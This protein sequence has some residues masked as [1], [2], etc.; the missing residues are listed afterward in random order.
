MGGTPRTNSVHVRKRRS[1][2]LASRPCVVQCRCGAY[3]C[4]D[5]AR[6][7]GTVLV[8]NKQMDER[9]RHG[10]LRAYRHT[11]TDFSNTFPTASSN[12]SMPSTDTRVCTVGTIRT[13]PRELR[14]F[15]SGE[16]ARSR[17]SPS[18]GACLCVAWCDLQSSVVHSNDTQD[19]R[20][21]RA[22][23]LWSPHPMPPP[24]TSSHRTT[25]RSS[26]SH[27]QSAQRLNASRVVGGKRFRPMGARTEL[28][29][30][31]VGL[32]GKVLPVI[33]PIIRI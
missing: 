23:F 17:K 18:L 30:F 22:L 9:R 28:V 21:R 8:T 31:F 20:D 26:G 25:H 12:S 19:T 4:A 6:L 13:T 2:S 11:F 7:L 5:P 1:L 3:H 15:F 24:T 16:S 10:S 33:L 29:C 32:T 27:N 14:F